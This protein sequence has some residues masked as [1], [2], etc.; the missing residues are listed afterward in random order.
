MKFKAKAIASFLCAAMLAVIPVA[1]CSSGDDDDNSVDPG[2]QEQPDDVTPNNPTN[3]TDPTDPT[4]PSDGTETGNPDGS[5]T[6]VEA[7]PLSLEFSEK[8]ITWVAKSHKKSGLNYYTGSESICYVSNPTHKGIQSLQMYIPEAYMNEDGTMNKTAVVNGY[9]V[10]TAPIIYWNS[11]GSYIGKGPFGLSETSVQSIKNYW[12]HNMVDYGFVVCMVG[13]RG[14]QTTNDEGGVIGRGPIAV[15]DLK[16]GVRFLKHND[17]DMPGDANKIISVGTSSGGA[18]S[19]LLGTSGNNSYYDTYLAEIGAYMG[20]D[21]DDSVFGTMAYCPIT[22]LPHADYAYEW[23]FNSDNDELTDFQK[24][25]SDKLKVKYAEY[26]NAMEL[27]DESGNELTLAEDG[28][29]S[30]TY[31]DWLIT[32]Y[33]ESFAR[34][35]QNWEEQY[36]GVTQNFGQGASDANDYEWLEWDAST[37]KAVI[38]APEGFS[39][40][41]DAIISE[42]RPRSKSVLAFDSFSPIG[43]DN[44]LFGE[45]NSKSGAENSA[46]HYSQGVAELINE[47]KEQFSDE[48]EQYYQSYYDQSHI[49]E[50]EDW[51]NYTNSYYFLTDGAG[52]S[53]ISPNF[54]LN[55]GALDSDTSIT[56]SATLSLLLQNAGINTEFNIMWDWGHNDCDTPTGLREWV[57]SICKS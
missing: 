41:L 2:K 42:I 19:A 3:P 48:W 29:H 34:Y 26:V 24:A 13:E 10:E 32:K 15:V 44:E 6:T 45:M 51:A 30:G 31:Y 36:K 53:D 11:H 25:L 4:Q 9:T 55:M 33:E 16:A 5:N 57:D 46:R 28:S 18:M 40:A 1:G 8:G 38:S 22:D 20:E 52:T 14:K 35:A 37:L 17:A 49:E 21:A 56:V 47:L 7:D 39:N 23:M 43:T 27:K 12:V 50:I 54:R